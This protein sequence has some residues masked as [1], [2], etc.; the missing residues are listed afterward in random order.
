MSLLDYWKQGKQLITSKNLQQLIGFAGEGYLSD[1]NHTSQEFCE[2]LNNMRA[3]LIQQYANNC[4][5]QSFK[6]YG[7]ALQDIVNEIWM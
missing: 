6:D 5:E 1:G 4:L 2:L 3:K 7:Y